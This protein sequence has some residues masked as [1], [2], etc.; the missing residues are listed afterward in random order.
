[1]EDW[2]TKPEGFLT[3]TGREILQGAGKV[4]AELAKSH[5]ELEFG[6]FRVLDDRRFESDFDHMVKRLPD[7]KLP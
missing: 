2:I 5:A 7:K 1:M 3:L 6:K 4:P